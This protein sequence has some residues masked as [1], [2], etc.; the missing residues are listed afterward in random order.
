MKELCDFQL[1]SQKTL[2][3]TLTL[4]RVCLDQPSRAG[5][6]PVGTGYGRPS[7]GALEAVVGQ[8]DT[9]LLSRSTVLDLTVTVA[10]QKQKSKK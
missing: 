4:L 5:R 8:A 6:P 1:N 7:P 3:D 10:L 2:K 9:P